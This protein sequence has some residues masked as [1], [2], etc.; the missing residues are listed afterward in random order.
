[1]KQDKSGAIVTAYW[2]GVT[3]ILGLLMREVNAED[4]TFSKAIS[5]VFFAATLT[6]VL[7]TIIAAMP[8]SPRE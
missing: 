5:Y 4:F 8:D 3:L 7:G 2:S 1:M 6:F